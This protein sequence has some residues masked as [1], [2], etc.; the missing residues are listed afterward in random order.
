MNESIE[1]VPGQ[2]LA[3]IKLN[4]NINDI[5]AKI[6][7]YYIIEEKDGVL[8]LNNGAITIGHENGG[9]IYS[10]MCDKTF[11]G[12]YNN[13]LWAGMS[14]KDVLDHS[15]KQVALGGCVVVDGINGIGLPLPDGY[16]DFEI[17][18]DF[19]PIDFIFEYLSIFRI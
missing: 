18:T 6:S 4:E 12:I 15:S 14:L 8:L 10:V 2:S 5:F 9:V 7:E 19:L 13:K 17:I 3:G 11:K 16:D 1:I